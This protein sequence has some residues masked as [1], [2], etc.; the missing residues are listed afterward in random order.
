MHCRPSV[1]MKKTPNK[2]YDKLLF[3]TE[4]KT[5]KFD[6]QRN[7]PIA[8]TYRCQTITHLDEQNILAPPHT[9]HS[10]DHS[11]THY[12]Q[13]HY[14]YSLLHCTLYFLN[15]PP[16]HF[17]HP[18]FISIRTPN[19]FVWGFLLYLLCFCLFCLLNRSPAQRRGL[20][21]TRQE[22]KYWFC[23][24]TLRLYLESWYDRR[25]AHTKTHT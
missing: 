4:Y 8:R 5:R 10:Q 2:K 13:P 14:T 19:S 12:R 25:Y 6:R 3:K 24:K 15:T 20:A 21:W 23:V 22:I 17:L 1:T 18:F 11:L 7:K 9:W 16:P